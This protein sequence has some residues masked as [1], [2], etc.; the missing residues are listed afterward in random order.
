M[1]FGDVSRAE[2]RA[3]FRSFMAEMDQRLQDFID[4]GAAFGYV[5]EFRI[6]E[7]RDIECF[8][9][10]YVEFTND[11]ETSLSFF[12]RYIGTVIIRTHGGYWTLYRGSVRDINHNMPVLTGLLGITNIPLNPRDMIYT[13]YYRKRPGML[14][15]IINTH[16]S[17][18]KE[19]RKMH[20][21]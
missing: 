17:A 20:L 18:L 2:A 6:S 16:I 11:L 1:A 9:D 7:C 3:T 19:A 10:E 14:E 4:I 21:I 8:F 12:S 5:F 13:Y 15:H